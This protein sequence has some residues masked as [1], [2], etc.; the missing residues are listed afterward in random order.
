MMMLYA[1]RARDQAGVRDK[2]CCSGYVRAATLFGHRKNLLGI[3]AAAECVCFDKGHCLPS[4][5]CARQFCG[6]KTTGLVRSLSLT[7][8]HTRILAPLGGC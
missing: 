7:A 4:G 5:I 8:A 3:A 2:K 1:A 6:E